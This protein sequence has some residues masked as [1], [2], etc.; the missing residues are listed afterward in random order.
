[1]NR[2]FTVLLLLL[3]SVQLSLA[4]D[5]TLTIKRKGGNETLLKLST[6]P[7]ITFEDESMVVTTSLTQI[8]IPLGDIVEYTV[9]GAASGIKTIPAVPEFRNGCVVFSDLPPG[10]PIC[11]HSIDGRLI[12]R[13]TIDY[14]GVGTVRIDNLPEGVNVISVL[15][16]TIKIIN[17]RN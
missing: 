13:H 10:T 2:K 8:F 7:V 6:N 17:K 4:D 11:V 3:A 16:K 9:S 15:N 12:N 14:T 5:T 1:M